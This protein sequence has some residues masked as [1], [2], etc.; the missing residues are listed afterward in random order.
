MNRL[1]IHGEE[2]EGTEE[3]GNERPHGVVEVED[4]IH[5]AV[6]GRT[7]VAGSPH[8]HVAAGMKGIGVQ[9][10]EAEMDAALG[11]V[12]LVAVVWD[13]VLPRDEIQDPE[14]G[15]MKEVL[16]IQEEV[17]VE[18][19][20]LLVVDAMVV[21]EVDVPRKAGAS[22]LGR[23]HPEKTPRPALFVSVV[24]PVRQFLVEW[25][26]ENQIHGIQTM[27]LRLNP[28]VGNHVVVHPIHLPLRA[29]FHHSYVLDPEV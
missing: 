26:F 15:E 10:E 21:V 7:G 4:E 24:R 29:S 9:V 27:T 18:A 3:V 22:S 14:E 6:A 2:E 13:D 16:H 20:G 28:L 17:V 11:M 12:G 8:D 23:E 5:G 19:A 1:D 25:P